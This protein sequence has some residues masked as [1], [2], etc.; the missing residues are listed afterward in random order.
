MIKIFKNV[1]KSWNF[2]VDAVKEKISDVLGTEAE[3]WIG[4]GMT[5]TLFECLKDRVEE[6]MESQPQPVSEEESSESE[7]SD[8][9]SSDAD[10]GGLS[11]GGSKVK[12]E[13]LTKAQK[14]RQWDQ[15]AVG[16]ER[17]RG[18]NWVDIVKHLSAVGNKDEAGSIPQNYDG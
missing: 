2:R 12:K 18:W 14:R 8:E 13:R 17:P 6:I 9:D 10:I 4:C 1:I 5:Y 7:E 15:A 11:I 16:G 3:Q